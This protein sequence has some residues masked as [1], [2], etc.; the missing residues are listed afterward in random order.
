MTRRGALLRISMLGA[1]LG[2]VA[3]PRGVFAQDVAEDGMAFSFDWLTERMQARAAEPF[4]PPSSDLPQF[5]R[6][7]D[8]DGYRFIQ[9][10]PLRAR[11][12]E[13]QTGWR[14]HAFHPGWLYPD[15]VDLY[16]VVDGVA[17]PFA[18]SSADF[19]YRGPL[20][21]RAGELAEFPGVA[22]FRLNH[23]LN[24]P[25]WRDEVLAFVGASYFRA[26]GRGN[27]YGISARGLALN[28]AL[29]VGEEFPRFSEFYLERPAPGSRTVVIHAAL[30]SQSVT[31]AYRF[32]VTPGDPTEMEVTARLFFRS[33]VAQ[34][35]VAPMTSMF[36]YAE[37]NRSDFEDYRPQ[38]HDSNGLAI[39]RASG[40]RLWRALS[41]PRQLASSYFFETNPRRFGLHQRDRDY[42]AYQ[43]AEARYE[44]RPSLDVEPI[45]DWGPGTVRLVEIPTRS[46][47]NDNIVAFW[48][49]Q[50]PVR[51]GDTR[52]YRYQLVWGMLPVS[53][54]AGL[55]Y[56]RETR[57]G[58]GGFAGGEPDP[59]LKKFVIDFAGT[60]LAQLPPDAE[61]E[62]EASVHNAEL[63]ESVL[64]KVEANDTWRLVL[65]VRVGGDAPVELVAFLRGYE[66]RLSET[67]LY[68]W[69]A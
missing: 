31:G 23:P 36:L 45:G 54:D 29:N 51:A 11:W 38:V 20:Q 57:I 48:V 68:Q 17:R 67:W 69:R 30:D 61:L 63:V 19:D 55:A 7:L 56:V 12:D 13:S 65:E 4:A 32:V 8:Y 10:N 28:T 46:E 22:G 14:L 60:R 35:G 25:D 58:P 37:N 39:T 15:P 52:E 34:L 53:P 40:D 49:P 42:E 1:L 59:N 3:L 26:L 16:E 66:Q 44:R 24:R 50:E 43:D 47:T 41:N 9:F 64:Y 33:D 27:L 2:T 18:F 62:V 21:E 5:L 6:D